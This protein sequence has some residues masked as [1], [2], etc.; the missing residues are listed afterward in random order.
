M[1]R[2]IIGSTVGTALSP[3]SIK[4]KLKP[5]TSVNG[6]QADENG[7][8]VI[9]FTDASGNIDLSGYATEEWVQKGYQPKGNYL[10]EHQDISD[11]LDESRLPEVINTALAQAK[12]SGEFD[13][14]DGQDGQDGKD[15]QHGQNGKDGYNPVRGTDYWTDSDIAE[16]KS[17]VDDAILGGTW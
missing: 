9:N 10:T 12:A 4:K 8:V 14:K 13:G 1:N 7:N 16:I 2:K 5:V 3:Q 15:G 11:K 6:K 17:Y